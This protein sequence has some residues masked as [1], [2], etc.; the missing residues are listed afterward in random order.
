MSRFE[1]QDLFGA[2]YDVRFVT[3]PFGKDRGATR[4][5]EAAAEERRRRRSAALV[6]SA[7]TTAVAKPL[8]MPVM[9]TRWCR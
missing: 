1:R 7:D 9:S 4:R 6:A 5:I 8:F 3:G 2:R